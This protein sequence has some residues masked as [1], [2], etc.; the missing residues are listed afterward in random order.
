MFEQRIALASSKV[1]STM[2]LLGATAAVLSPRVSS[3]P[4]LTTH[5]QEQGVEEGQRRG[6]GGACVGCFAY[7]VDYLVCVSLCVSL[8]VCVYVCETFS[9]VV[10]LFS[11]SLSL[12]LSLVSFLSFLSTSR[13]GRR[14]LPTSLSLSHTHT[15]L[16]M[17]REA[18]AE[19]R[20]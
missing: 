14:P 9:V 13:A 2:A 7:V 18:N 1:V 11:L 15:L 16:E 3:D 5:S 17:V 6:E 4:R 19:M 20:D 8:C 10:R 12:S